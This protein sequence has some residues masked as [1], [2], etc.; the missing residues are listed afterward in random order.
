MQYMYNFQPL[1]FGFAHGFFKAYFHATFKFSQ[2][3]GIISLI[4]YLHLVLIQNSK[5]VG[6]SINIDKILLL[7]LREFLSTFCTHNEFLTY[8]SLNFNLLSLKRVFFFTNL[9]FSTKRF[10]SKST[11][12]NNTAIP[13]QLSQ[14]HAWLLMFLIYFKY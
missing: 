9:I 1:T 8:F 4:R 10:Y 14:S 13:W 12:F 3:E 11:R 5:W 2:F 7:L 6:F